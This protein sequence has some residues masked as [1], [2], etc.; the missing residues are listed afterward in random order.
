MASSSSIRGRRGEKDI[1]VEKL[2]N[3]RLQ[4]INN[5][6]IFIVAG[7]THFRLIMQEVSSVVR[8]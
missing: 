7:Y 2:R 3:H 4:K 8:S 6:E 5:R 1:L